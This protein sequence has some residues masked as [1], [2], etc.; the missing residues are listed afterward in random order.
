MSSFGYPAAKD[1]TKKQHSPGVKSE[2]D[3]HPAKF[4]PL[5]SPYARYEMK[6]D[7]VNAD[8]HWNEH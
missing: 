5:S 3:F 7:T 6:D 1:L 8:Q 4:V 2:T